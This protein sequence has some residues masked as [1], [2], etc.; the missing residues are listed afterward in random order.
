MNYAYIV[1]VM[2]SILEKIS[3]SKL[4][5]QLIDLFFKR[6][7]SFKEKNGIYILNDREFKMAIIYSL[8]TY[9]RAV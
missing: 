5:V 6:F 4:Q 2:R 8:Q 1:Y 3:I 7:Y 9:W